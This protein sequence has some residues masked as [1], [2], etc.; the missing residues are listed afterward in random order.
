MAPVVRDHPYVGLMKTLVA[1]SE[2][3]KGWDAYDGDPVMTEALLGALQL[4]AS[5]PRLGE[6]PLPAAGLAP[7][8]A[9]VLRWLTP[10]QEIELVYRGQR[11]GEYSVADRATQDVI[12]EGSLRDIVDPLKE[13]VD[14]Y[15]GQPFRAQPW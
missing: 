13:I 12:L 10:D 1:L 15:V 4:A 3:T 11:A 14:P 2:R 7:D 8:G 9:V 6:I 5:L